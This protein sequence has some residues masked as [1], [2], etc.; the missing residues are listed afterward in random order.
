MK[1][2]YKATKSYTFYKK[3]L[4]KRMPKTID[5]LMSIMKNSNQYDTFKREY[6]T[7][8]EIKRSKWNNKF[9]RK[10]IKTY[11]DFRKKGI[12]TSSHGVA[13]IV[14]RIQ[15]KKI[16]LDEI[17]DT[18]NKPINYTECDKK[19]NTIKNI[20]YYNKFRVVTN[21]EDTEIISV[22]KNSKDISK[23]KERDGTWKKK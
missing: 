7:I 3:Y 4:N 21:E 19:N 2:R 22:V 8:K 12:E 11:D 17:I 1:T 23:D 14:Q 9:K 13:R 16:T 10:A 15:D 5:D 20:R 6:N 18:Y